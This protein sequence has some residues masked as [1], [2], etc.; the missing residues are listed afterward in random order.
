MVKKLVELMYEYNIGV[1]IEKE[2]KIKRIDD[3]FFDI[4]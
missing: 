3:D 4:F 1:T 2:F